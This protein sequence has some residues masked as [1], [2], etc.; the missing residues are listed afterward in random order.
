MKSFI[1]DRYRFLYFLII[2][3]I[4]VAVISGNILLV[5]QPPVKAAEGGFPH[6][7][8]LQLT[9][10][11]E[12]EYVPDQIIVKFKETTLTSLETDLN[13]ILE[14]ELIYTSLFAGFKVLKIP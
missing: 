13:E 6:I 5:F 1:L 3:L 10:G 12:E 7:D 2:P 11:P 4:I 9:H 14:A 8:E